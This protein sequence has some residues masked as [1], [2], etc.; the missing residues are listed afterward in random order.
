MNDKQ[1]LNRMF[2]ILFNPLRSGGNRSS[3]VSK[4][5]G[6]FKYVLMR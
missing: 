5:A 3:Y 4:A 1:I 2:Q 6:L